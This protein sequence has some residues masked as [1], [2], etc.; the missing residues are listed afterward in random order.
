MTPGELAKK[1]TIDHKRPLL[2]SFK[3]AGT[4]NTAGISG[5]KEVSGSR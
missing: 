3:H 1:Q 2:N 4:G 5:V